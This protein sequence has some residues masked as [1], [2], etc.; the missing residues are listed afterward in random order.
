MDPIRAK[1]YMIKAE[2]SLR[3]AKIALEQ[4]AYDN[5]VMSSVHAAINSLDA[6][7]T[8]Y[9]GKRS[10]GSHSDVVTMIRGIFTG[11]EH[12][13]ISR[14]FTSLMSLKNASE[15]QPELMS[16]DAQMS[17]LHAERVVAKVK[18]RVDTKK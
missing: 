2:N 16:R 15:Y 18:E 4:G 7:T 6:L 1:N 14:Q 13:D 5:A 10:S 8:L 12:T 9:L 17:V 11:K 3:M